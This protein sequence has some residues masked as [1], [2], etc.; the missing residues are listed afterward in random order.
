M[1]NPIL[2]EQEVEAV[3]KLIEGMDEVWKAHK[4]FR[5]NLNAP[6]NELERI[7][8]IVY[9]EAL[10]DAMRGLSA[11]KTMI[12]CSEG[13]FEAIATLHGKYDVHD[14]L[15]HKMATMMAEDLF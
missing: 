3:K 6:C 9:L 4:D 10:K 14:V 2:P 1:K 11:L 5:P 7:H 12:E 15:L 8:T 13:E